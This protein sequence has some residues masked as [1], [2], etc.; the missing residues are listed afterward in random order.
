VAQHSFPG[1]GQDGD[2]K[3]PVPGVPA[4]DGADDDD[5]YPGWLADIDA[6]RVQIPPDEPPPSGLTVCLGEAGDVDAAD[7]ARIAEGLTGTGFS[8]HG[9]A[10]G[11]RPGPVLG[12][13][14]ARA[15][16]DLRSLSDEGLLGVVSTAR[17]MQTRYEYE[18]LAAVAEF[19]RRS[20]ERYEASMARGDKPWHRDGEYAAEELGMACQISNRTAGQR[21][22]YA[23]HLASRLPKTFAG[24]ADG[25]VHGF[26]A[27]II[28]D[29]TRFLSDER[30]AEADQTLAAAAPDL[31][32]AELRRKAARLEIKLDPEGTRRR[33][34]EAARKHRRVEARREESGNAVL[35]GR[36][37][38]AGQVLAAKNSMWAEAAALH[39]AG[40][41]GSLRSLRA[42][43]FLDRLCRIDSWERLNPPHDPP[44][45]YDD[46]DDPG[47]DGAPGPGEPC[48]DDPG[49]HFPDNSF[50]A[51]SFP[52]DSFPDDD[53]Y[54]TGEHDDDANGDDDDG[55]DDD[56]DDSGNGGPGSGPHGPGSPAGGK[57]PL[58]AS[59]H[60]L[61]HDGTLMGWSNAPAEATGFGLLDPD[62]AREVIEAAGRHPRTRWCV[63][64]LGKDGEAVAHGCARGQHPWTPPVSSRDGPANARDG[65]EPDDYQRAQLAQFL[66]QL[67]ITLTP[68]AKGTCDHAQRE[69]RYI[70]SRK[71][72][73]LVRA[74]TA[75]CPAPGCSAQA[76][77]NEI[78]HTTPWPAGATD[79][80][81]LS[82]PCSRHHHA[83]HAPGWKLEQ[84]E[85]GVMHWTTPSGRSF[86]T[87]PTRY[88][89]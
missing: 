39:N 55:D 13:L 27:K 44:G 20:E 87:R 62:E 5:E 2:D 51:S 58:P 32:P 6:G 11:M 73:H 89:E 30:A 70:P 54:D 78:D 76:I 63:T 52:D 85:P 53:G 42:M 3:P 35:A 66:R 88:D 7:L 33:K 16:E 40:M 74:R 25:S 84:P 77:Y 82:P 21:M 61:V 43:V 29:Y 31:S 15:V 65:T 48:G 57:T 14:T 36:E 64:V 10:D 67:N 12:A 18:E 68:I 19:A 86:T 26:K 28:Y 47:D 56:G 1:P 22:E 45:G 49:G 81:D 4:W 71:L 23:D 37:L 75:T 69:D 9:A 83:K 79:E 50:P 59:V 80:C 41:S 38:P 17:R 72:K 46:Y 60:L 8:P 24:M 34:E